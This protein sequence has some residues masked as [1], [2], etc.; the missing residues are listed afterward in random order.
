MNVLPETGIEPDGCQF[1]SVQLGL[2]GCQ[3]SWYSKMV[4]NT[5]RTPTSQRSHSA[6]MSQG[7]GA[8]AAE[9]REIAPL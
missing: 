8:D 6:A 9:F 5:V 1:S 7:R 4:E 3:Y 2:S